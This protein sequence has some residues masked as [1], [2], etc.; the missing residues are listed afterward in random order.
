MS[1]LSLGQTA[2]STTG[3]VGT[4]AG[5]LGG[6]VPSIGSK[7]TK[8]TFVQR[9]VQAQGAGDETMAG[10]LIDQAVY[11]GWIQGVPDAAV[12]QG[13]LATV[14]T[15]ATPKWRAYIESRLG[16]AALQYDFAG[17]VV[18]GTATLQGVTPIAAPETLGQQIARFLGIPQ[19]ATAAAKEGGR[20]VASGIVKAALVVGVIIGAILLIRVVRR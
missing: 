20:E 8:D 7:F 5:F 9:F 15:Q 4:V 2:L 11:H 6:L 10:R 16:G 1:L 12:W 13:L 18:K 17:Q 14:Y 19:T 3:P